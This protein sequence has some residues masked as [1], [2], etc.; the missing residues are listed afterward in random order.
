MGSS[1]L[2]GL[3]EVLKKMENM[4]TG[5]KNKHIRKALKKA[6]VPMRDKVKENAKKLDDPKTKEK[7]WRNVQIQSGKS[8]E[9]ELKYRVGIRGGAKKKS[10]KGRGPGGDTWYFRLIEFGTRYVPAVP[11]IR[12]A[13]EATKKEAQQIFVEELRKSIIEEVRK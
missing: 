2:K 11:F 3:D 10:D 9:N 5:T 4:R 8:K 6:L 13:F 7:I 1:P 12:P